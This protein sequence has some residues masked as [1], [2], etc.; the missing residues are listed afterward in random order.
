MEHDERRSE[1]TIARVRN[2]RASNQTDGK[3]R[4][5]RTDARAK[6]ACRSGVLRE[7]AELTCHWD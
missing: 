5:D 6:A 7:L 4:S 2:L 1:E 3:T